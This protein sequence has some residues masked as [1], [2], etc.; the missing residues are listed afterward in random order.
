MKR[1]LIIVPIIAMVIFG[2]CTVKQPGTPKWNIE[3]TIPI[4]DKTYPLSDIIDDSTNTWA[5]DDSLGNWVSM[6]GDSLFINYADSIERV[7]NNDSL[8]ADAVN[9]VAQSLVGDL[10]VT[11]PGT[12]S[13]IFLVEEIDPT[14][15]PGFYPVPAFD[16][17]P[18]TSSLAPYTEFDWVL[19]VSKIAG[20]EAVPDTNE[21]TITLTNNL[22]FPIENM[23]IDLYG[24]DP[25][26]LLYSAFFS[27]LIDPGESR[28]ITDTLSTSTALDNE[29]YIDINGHSPGTGITPVNITANDNLN[30]GVDLSPLA[31]QEAAAHISS[32]SFDTLSYFSL[33]SEDEIISATIK[34]AYIDYTIVNNTGLYNLITFTI[35][36]FVN[37]AG[38]PFT[39]N[40]SIA[41]GATYD[42]L[43]VS[44]TDYV[45]TTLNNQIYASVVV[46]IIDSNNPSYYPAG[47]FAVVGAAQSVDVD[48]QI[49]NDN[50]PIG[51]PEQKFTF[52]SF[53][54][55][56]VTKTNEI[57]PTTLEVGEMPAGLDSLS[58][59]Q[60]ILDLNLTSTIGVSVPFEIELFAYRDGLQK[61]SL[62][63]QTIIQAGAMSEPVTTI[64][65]F[66]DAA[67]LINAFPDSIQ[68]TGR[69]H[70]GGHIYLEDVN[71]NGAYVEGFYY[72]HAPFSLGVGETSLQP[73]LTTLDNGFDNKLL[74]A[75]LTINLESHFPLA[76]DAYILACLD[77]NQFNNYNTSGADIDTFFHLPLPT[78]KVD[79]ITGY[80]LQPGILPVD[81]RTQVLNQSQLELFAS[82]SPEQP[83]F[84]QTLITIN[85]S[86]GLNVNF[87]PDDYIIVGASAH[88]ILSVDFE[89]GGN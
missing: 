86:E 9:Q 55:N 8:V 29:M 4:A 48:F 14:I 13:T 60:A 49:Y 42:T 63:K 17:T 51:N 18:D 30:I 11:A 34:D 52:K 70:I 15:Q 21:V 23:T 67:D 1:I 78:A 62:Y 83:L 40:L 2:G 87:S 26:A 47:T 24:K 45:L 74:E 64:V 69:Y 33:E 59:A 37:A 53:E 50:D 58:V 22:P 79:T 43:H 46:N 80:V 56:L 76:G 84:I 31:V 65:S 88:L 20:G 54:A 77:S 71:F 12:E 28:V 61:A 75:T 89:E 36:D 27:G 66:D 3:M 16:I 19:L 39:D 10:V 82:A 7:V 44:L 32:Q 73:Q 5:Q 25:D 72:L 6:S 38:E 85:S 35:P 41:P 68:I 81:Q 57:D